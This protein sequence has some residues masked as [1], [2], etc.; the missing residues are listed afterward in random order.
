MKVYI[1][2]E[3]S[4]YGLWD[5]ANGKVFATLEAA[6]AYSNEYSKKMGYGLDISEWEV[7]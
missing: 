2:Y 7:E 6:E 5:M 4:D 1:V 3:I